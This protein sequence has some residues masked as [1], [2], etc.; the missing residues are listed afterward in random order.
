M[1]FS[2]ICLPLIGCFVLLFVDKTNINFIRNFSLFW[3]LLILNASVCLL[4]FFD[5]TTTQ[6]QFLETSA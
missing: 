3:S 6:F 4:F 2:L 5:P 1:L